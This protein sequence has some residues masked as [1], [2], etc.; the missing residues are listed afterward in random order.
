MFGAI[1]YSNEWVDTLDEFKTKFEKMLN[2]N[3][4]AKAEWEG[5]SP[6]LKIKYLVFSTNDGLAHKDFKFS[7][8]ALD[9]NH[10]YQLADYVG[11]DINGE[12]ITIEDR[13]ETNI[14]V[15]HMIMVRW[16]EWRRAIQEYRT[17]YNNL[18]EYVRGNYPYLDELDYD[19]FEYRR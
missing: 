8:E 9:I 13:V 6:Y 16:H 15:L 7:I 12:Y 5:L 10:L 2:E 19:P 1:F 17:M 18:T 11:I 4:A 14:A 3:E